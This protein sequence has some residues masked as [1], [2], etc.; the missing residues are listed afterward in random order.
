M[1]DSLTSHAAPRD[2]QPAQPRKSKQH[3]HTSLYVSS[4][5]REQA[6]EGDGRCKG[7]AAVCS[8]E[9][10][11]S[12]KLQSIPCWILFWFM[13]YLSQVGVRQELTGRAGSQGSMSSS[14]LQAL[15]CPSSGKCL[16]AKLERQKKGFHLIPEG[17]KSV[18]P[19]PLFC[20][21]QQPL[22]WPSFENG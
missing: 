4:C 7:E 17:C 2:E 3:K 9:I 19:P 21:V 20:S 10:F 11:L 16:T 14:S 6:D 15:L 18:A 1:Q 12:C 5:A 22:P 8:C 13:G